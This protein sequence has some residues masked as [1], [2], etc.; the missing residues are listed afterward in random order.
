MCRGGLG[1]SNMNEY[2]GNMK[3][4]VENMKQY[5]GHMKKCTSQGVYRSRKT[6][7][8]TD[9]K[10]RSRKSRKVTENSRN[11]EEI[12]RELGIFRRPTAISPNVTSSQKVH[13]SNV[14]SQEPVYRR[15]AQHFSKS[16][17]HS[18]KCEVIKKDQRCQVWRNCATVAQSPSL[19][20]SVCG[21]MVA[22]LHLR[23]CF[24]Q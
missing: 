7:K 1:I 13:S 3:K 12:R 17:G 24:F 22:Q 11:N 8:V 10:R 9:F 23:E 4:Y 2:V 15:R 6:R 16:L 21:T 19:W 14:T 20:G 5:V 18:P